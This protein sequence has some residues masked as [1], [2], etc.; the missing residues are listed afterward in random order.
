MPF[1][2]TGDAWRRRIDAL[3]AKA[4]STEFGL[5][6]EALIA[7]AHELMV[8]HSISES[9]LGT[10]AAEV[11]LCPVSIGAPY[12]SAKS[13]LLA[14]IATANCC[15]V[16][17]STTGRGPQRGAL[18]GRD[19]DRQNTLA[20]YA[21]LSLYAFDA[22]MS[23]SIPPWE[24]PRRF[25]HGFLL[26]FAVRIGER[27]TQASDEVSRSGEFGA[28]GLVLS[29]RADAVDSFM[30]ARFP[31]LGRLTRTASSASGAQGGRAAADRAAL[32]SR[33]GASALGEL[34][35]GS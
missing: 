30:A 26:S 10:G 17:F 18:I 13:S 20:M 6:A 19:T 16:V 32:G 3:L 7:K 14:G 29:S 28:A 15:R 27:L 25:R 35:A 4:E 34:P 11:S 5:E 23:A 31:R 33:I 9:M 2:P 1:D 22:M 24:T 21:W 8:R 12:A